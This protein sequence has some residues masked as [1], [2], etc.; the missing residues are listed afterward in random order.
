MIMPDE[1]QTKMELGDT[2]VMSWYP[3]VAEKRSITF[4]Y[5][6]IVCIWWSSLKQWIPVLKIKG[7][8]I[9]FSTFHPYN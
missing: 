3:H 8:I 1:S 4:L 2:G 6:D 5:H 7:T 9:Y